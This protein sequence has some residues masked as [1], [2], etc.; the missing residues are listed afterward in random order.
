M[1]YLQ[2]YFIFFQ[3]GILA[4]GGGYA[5]LPLIQ[6]YV[7]E[8]YAW[9]SLGEMTDLISISQMTPG[10]IAV[11]AATFVGTKVAGISGS[12]VATLGIVTPAFILLSILAQFIFGGKKIQLLSDILY[13]IRP[14]IVG[15]IA[16][17]ALSMFQNSV[18]NPLEFI[19]QP[20]PLITFVVGV[21]LYLKKVDITKLILIGALLGILLSK[22]AQFL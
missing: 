5:A 16:I 2:I 18:F 6:H 3:I 19:L 17:A 15:L 1:E 14:G 20:I 9:L 4:F 22:M 21:I 10:P 12:I 8:E 7:V 11:N 13:G